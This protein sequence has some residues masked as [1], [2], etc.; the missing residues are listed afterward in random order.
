MFFLY[1]IDEKSVS[2]S[3]LTFAVQCCVWVHLASLIVFLQM[4]KAFA[5]EAGFYLG[6][7]SESSKF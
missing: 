6:L 7:F 2:V 4:G 1:C 3:I 5:L